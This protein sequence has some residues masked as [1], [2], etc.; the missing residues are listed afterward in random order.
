MPIIQLEPHPITALPRHP[1]LPG[2]TTGPN[3][4]DFVRDTLEEAQS[5][6][7]QF[8]S[9]LKAD[10]KLHTSPPSNAK[11]KLSQ[12][13]RTL[14]AGPAPQEGSDPKKEFW[15]C[16]QS[17]HKDC[18]VLEGT[19]TWREFNE[20][21]RINHAEHEK[22][23]TPSVSSVH[24]LLKWS[25][26]EQWDP[27]TSI[28]V[29]GITYSQFNIEL[30]LIVHTFNPSV[31]IRPRAF[32]S[33]SMS[34]SYDNPF[35]AAP[36]LDADGKE[37]ACKGFLTVQVPFYLFKPTSL[38]SPFKDLYA[39]IKDAVPPRTI[40]ANYASIERAEH[41][42]PSA[43]EGTRSYQR[44]RWT[45][46]TTSEADGGIPGWVQRSWM[47]GGVPKAV[48]AD[49]GLFIGWCMKKRQE[50]KDEDDM[51]LEG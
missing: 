23:Y 20:G 38:D 2:E 28:V 22:E 31:L 25:N 12:G 13:W 8:P 21:L 37:C 47:L 10:S 50:K 14:P 16:R 39:Q 7:D 27:D 41:L 42:L 48:V 51:R 5:L 6:L 19:A 11:V 36:K 40:F 35:C 17:D 34:A 44:I 15:V 18:N 9:I 43:K 49:V 46:A 45:M 3:I 32:L 4:Q 30:N 26:S 24:H 29:S 1:N 33:W